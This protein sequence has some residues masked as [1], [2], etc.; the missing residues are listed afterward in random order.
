MT[1]EDKAS[2]GS[3][4]LCTK[5]SLKLSTQ[6]ECFMYVGVIF[7]L[8]TQWECFLYVCVIFILSTQ[9]ECFVYMF[10]SFSYCRQYEW[11][12]WYLELQVSFCQ[13]AT[14]YRA[15]C[16]ALCMSASFSYYRQYESAPCNQMTICK[17]SYENLAHIVHNT[18]KN[19][20]R[21]HNSVTQIYAWLICF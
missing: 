7:E 15:L 16:D 12:P 13:T 11:V 19:F 10:V 20:V 21:L 6:W 1:Y 18:R 8:S 5:S 3:S 17:S 4:P 9:W 2:Y 14:N